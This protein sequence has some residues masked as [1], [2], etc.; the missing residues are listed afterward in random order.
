MLRIA[1]MVSDTV[2]ITIVTTVGGVLTAL[3]GII[4]AKINKV[5]VMVNDRATKQDEA[6][7]GL[8]AT[9]EELVRANQQ[10]LNTISKTTPPGPSLPQRPTNG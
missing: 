6:I 7:A 10:W 2:L 5:H 1:L 9:N 3:I 8:R 4:L